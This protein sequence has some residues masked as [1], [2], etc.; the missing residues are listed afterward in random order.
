MES[1][2]HWRSETVTQR[3]RRVPQEGRTDTDTVL[4]GEEYPC[5]RYNLIL[6]R[7]TGVELN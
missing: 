3:Y 5:G 6:G 1:E 7:I 2:V 4:Q